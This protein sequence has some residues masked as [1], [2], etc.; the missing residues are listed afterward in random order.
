V[1]PDGISGGPDAEEKQVRC[2]AASF[3][4]WDGRR[5]NAQFVTPSLSIRITRLECGTVV[6]EFF[7][8]FIADVLAKGEILLTSTRMPQTTVYGRLCGHRP[9]EVRYARCNLPTA[10]RPVPVA[11]R[12]PASPTSV[13]RESRSRAT[14]TSCACGTQ[15]I[16]WVVCA[17][18]TLPDDRGNRR[19]GR[20]SR[21]P[22]RLRVEHEPCCHRRNSG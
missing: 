13:R 21:S 22:D 19:E 3:G 10:T 15:T 9:P 12:H 17:P 7:G 5:S 20:D 14:N 8:P 6:H 18:S 2:V 4:R 11:R 16:R 1:L